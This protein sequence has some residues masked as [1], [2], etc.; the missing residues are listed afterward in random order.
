MN[1]A[2]LGVEVIDVID[3]YDGPDTTGET[4]ETFAAAAQ[5]APDRPEPMNDAQRKR[6]NVEFRNA[7]YTDRDERIGFVCTVIGRTISTSNEL[8]RAESSNVIDAL[9]AEQAEAQEQS[10]TTQTGDTN[11]DNTEEHGGS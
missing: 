11:V 3:D 8:T 7:G 10:E 5:P 1:R 9:M 4:P 2:G 6:M